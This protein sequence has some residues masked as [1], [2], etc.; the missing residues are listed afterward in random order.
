MVIFTDA[1]VEGFPPPIDPSSFPTLTSL[2]IGLFAGGPSI[3]L[4]NILESISLAPALTS[5]VIEY[6]PWET[7][8]PVPSY[9]WIGM[10]KWLARMANRATVDGGLVLMLRWSS[11]REPAWE[12][13]FSEFR[14]AGGRIETGPEA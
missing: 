8:Q 14:E 10:F 11:S 9:L 3:H 5:I 7:A 2:R 13:L 12:G 4:V 1:P 6:G